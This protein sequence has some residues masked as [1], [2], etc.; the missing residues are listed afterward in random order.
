MK[1]ITTIIA[2]MSTVLFLAPSCKKCDRDQNNQVVTQT[3][4]ATI[5]ENTNYTFSLPASNNSSVFQITSQAANY[6]ASQLNTAAASGAVTY[7]Y[8]PSKDFVGVNQI[9]LSNAIAS[10]N[11]VS[12]SPQNSGCNHGGGHQCN[13]GNDHDAD[14]MPSMVITVNIT[15]KSTT[16]ITSINK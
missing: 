13:K 8:T 10:S 4:N 16:T 9:I 2:L 15:V 3:V 12:A 1:K 5:D 6:S 11:G 7:V 14:D